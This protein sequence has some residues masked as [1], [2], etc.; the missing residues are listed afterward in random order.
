VSIFILGVTSAETL[1]Q[2]QICKKNPADPDCVQFNIL[3]LSQA[4]DDGFMTARFI[5]FMEKS[6]YYITQD[7]YCD[8]DPRDE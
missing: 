5:D 7:I 6:S 1:T 2:R 8:F 4:G 3:S